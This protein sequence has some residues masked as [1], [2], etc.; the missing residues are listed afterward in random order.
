[1]IKA[2]I[3]LQQ[4][5]ERKIDWDE[6]VPSSI[7][8]SWR[9]ELGSVNIPRCYFVSD[10][11]SRPLSLELLLMPL[12]WPMLLWC[13][14]VS[15]KEH[16][17]IVM[18]KTKLAPIKKLTIPRLELRG[19]YLVAT[20]HQTSPLSCVQA[21]TDSTIVLN[22]LDGSPRRFK[23]YVGNRV[24]SIIDLVPPDKWK[25]VTTL[26]IVPQGESTPQSYL[27]THFGG[28]AQ[29]EPSWNLA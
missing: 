12:K 6:P 5:W 13:T 23:T 16:T 29:H 27:T 22:W 21:W 18:S 2:K 1:V 26:Q 25:Q 17:L 14:Y 15:P 20:S 11:N 19:A 8:D 9:S 10:Q 24:S 3:L 7:Q 4:L 28:M